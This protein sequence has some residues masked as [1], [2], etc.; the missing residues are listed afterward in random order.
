M[1]LGTGVIL[2]DPLAVSE[3]IFIGLLFDSATPFLA[4]YPIS[5]RKMHEDMCS[6]QRSLLVADTGSKKYPAEEDR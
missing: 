3:I 1:L 5:A 2:E 4:I 6:L